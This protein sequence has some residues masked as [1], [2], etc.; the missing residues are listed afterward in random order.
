M[1]AVKKCV[2]GVVGVLYDFS[3]FPR[4]PLDIEVLHGWQL[5]PGDAL[6]S[7]DDSLQGFAVMLGAAPIPCQTSSVS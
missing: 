5:R 6:S 3:S 7:F 1:E 2:A 4:A